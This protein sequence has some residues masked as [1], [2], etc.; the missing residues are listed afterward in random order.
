MEPRA[1]LAR[2]LLSF[3]A[4]ATHWS[5]QRE[6]PLNRPLDPSPTVYVLP[7][8]KGGDQPGRHG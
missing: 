5:S 7:Q 3:S 4:L 6:V 2:Y 1:F 8:N